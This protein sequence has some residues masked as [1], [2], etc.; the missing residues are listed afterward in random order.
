MHLWFEEKD[1]TCL[2]LFLKIV[3]SYQT[4]CKEERR[5]SY[6]ATYSS[7]RFLCSSPQKPSC[8]LPCFVS[9]LFSVLKMWYTECEHLSHIS[10]L[11]KSC[12]DSGAVQRKPGRLLANIQELLS[13]SGCGDAAVQLQG[14]R[15][16][17]AMAS[18]KPHWAAETPERLPHPVSSGACVTAESSRLGEVAQFSAP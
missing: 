17:P 10:A 3:D 16:P 13:V 4:T 14:W 7:R 11:Q 1:V 12:C 15:A 2:Q 5:T 18:L 8:L 6:V 9:Q